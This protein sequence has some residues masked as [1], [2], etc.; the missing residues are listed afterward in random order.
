MAVNVDELIARLEAGD[1]TDPFAALLAEAEAHDPRMRLVR[2]IVERRRRA[3][4]AEAGDGEPPAQVGLDPARLGQAVSDACAELTQLRVRSQRLASALGACPACWG[5]DERCRTCGGD[6]RPG[7]VSPDVAL[8]RELVAPAVARLA[9]SADPD[10]LRARRDGP[11]V[12]RSYD[13]ATGDED[14][15][16]E[17]SEP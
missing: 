4:H 8:F 6:G 3:A 2:A 11:R 17:R 14:G 10:P 9:R 16:K 7:A 5:Q 12:T 1:E 13:P 15:R